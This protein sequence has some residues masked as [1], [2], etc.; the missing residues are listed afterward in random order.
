[1]INE[2]LTKGKLKQTGYLKVN[3]RWKK[4]E[5]RIINNATLNYTK[6]SNDKRFDK[7]IG[8][9]PSLSGAD[10][11]TSKGKAR[12]MLK[13]S[14]ISPDKKAKSVW[15]YVSGSAVKTNVPI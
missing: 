13:Y 4:T 7:S 1:M 15:E 2:Y 11:Y 10:I 6:W 14:S 12:I 5:S 9:V 3:G 8:A